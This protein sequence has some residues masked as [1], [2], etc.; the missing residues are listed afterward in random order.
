MKFCS[1]CNRHVQSLGWASHR[2]GK[3]HVANRKKQNEVGKEK[4][5]SPTLEGI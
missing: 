1:A 5:F 3:V 4:S 2:A